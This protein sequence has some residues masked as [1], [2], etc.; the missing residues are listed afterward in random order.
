MKTK[1]S[2]S[3]DHSRYSTQAQSRSGMSVTEWWLVHLLRAIN[4]CQTAIIY[5][6]ALDVGFRG[7]Y[8][9]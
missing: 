3:R 4:S 5:Q 2:V 6:T 1:L 8:A 9:K 7:G